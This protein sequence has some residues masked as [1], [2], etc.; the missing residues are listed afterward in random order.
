M[1]IST[2]LLAEKPAVA[3]A[4]SMKACAVIV[5]GG[6]AAANVTGRA[7]EPCPGPTPFNENNGIV[8]RTGSIWMLHGPI[9][10]VPLPIPDGDRRQRR[11][12]PLPDL[13]RG[14]HAR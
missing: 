13:Q 1:I 7:N 11:A 2:A 8:N 12:E 10:V 6:R 5:S 4:S 3:P 9:G 14:R